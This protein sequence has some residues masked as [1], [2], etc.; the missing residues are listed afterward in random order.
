MQLILKSNKLSSVAS[1]LILSLDITNAKI[2]PME[3]FKYFRNNY[4]LLFILPLLGSCSQK[5][6]IEIDKDSKSLVLQEIGSEKEYQVKDNAKV[7]KIIKILNR[8]KYCPT[9]FK[10]THKLVV[11]NKEILVFKNYAKYLGRPYCLDL[12]IEQLLLG[13]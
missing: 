9:K 7:R 3:Y 5:Y 8:A 12:D 4:L 10:P 13:T 1:R 2:I 11:D 6:S